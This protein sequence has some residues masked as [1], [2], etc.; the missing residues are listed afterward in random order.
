[1]SPRLLNFFAVFFFLLTVCAIAWVGIVYTN[2]ATALNPFPPPT[3][4]PTARLLPVAIIT[5]LP[6]QIAEPVTPTP[7]AGITQT[8]ALLS[9][10]QML[11][12]N[13][14]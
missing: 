14:S 4:V 9:Q 11:C 5:R 6:T 1:M 12:Q 13:D 10:S 2:P 7:P 8:V 3:V